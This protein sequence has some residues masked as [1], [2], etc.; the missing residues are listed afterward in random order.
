MIIWAVANRV[1][2]H[3]NGASSLRHIIRPDQSVGNL[4]NDQ[5]E[6]K[7]ESVELTVKLCKTGR[8]GDEE[9][10]ERN[11]GALDHSE[12]AHVKNFR[13]RGA[14]GGNIH[15]VGYEPLVGI[16]WPRRARSV[17][18]GNAPRPIVVHL[19]I[20]VRKLPSSVRVAQLL[21]NRGAIALVHQ[22]STHGA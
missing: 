13:S 9:G 3:A 19:A 15:T 20:L 11:I 4:N 21:A 12:R 6:I 2:W 14:F 8:S 1:Y 18:N 5:C 10:L 17:G 22:P 16:V 7:E